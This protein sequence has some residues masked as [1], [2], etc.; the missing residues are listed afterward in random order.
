MQT[1]VVVMFN[2]PVNFLL[3][4]PVQ[5]I[6]LQVDNFLRSPVIALDLALSH[7]MVGPTPGMADA[8]LRWYAVLYR[9]NLNLFFISAPGQNDHLQLVFLFGQTLFR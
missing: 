2:E 1:P 3:Q 9:M 6:F 5:V 8:T 7:G 4:L